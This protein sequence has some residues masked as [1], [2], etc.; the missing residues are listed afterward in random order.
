MLA[1][2]IAHLV[3]RDPAWLLAAAT[4]ESLFFFQP[5]TR[6]ARMKWQEHAEYLCDELAARQQ[7]SGLPLARALAR[8]AEWRVAQAELLAPALAEEPR[9]LLGR[10][11]A[12][13]G[14]GSKAPRASW[15]ARAA[16]TMLPVVILCVSPTFAPGSVRGWGA[17]AFHWADHLAPGQTI[18]V[19]GVLGSIRIEPT[20]GESVVV[21]ATRHGRARSP[22]IHFETLRTLDGFT[23]A[24][25]YPTPA[26]V[27]AN[28]ATPG[29]TGQYNTR[30]NDVEVEFVVHVPPGVNVVA[31]CSAGNITSGVVHGVVRARCR[32]GDI[33]ISTTEYAN[34]E[35]ESGNIRAVMGSA[36]WMGR[37]SL[38]TRA[39]DIRL[40][41]PAAAALEVEARTVTG[42]IRSDFDLGQVRPS[43]WSRLAPRGSLGS[44]TRAT[45]GRGGRSLELSTMAGNIELVRR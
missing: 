22:D 45:L 2:E 15:T 4:L 5:L 26:G 37:M 41:L 25:V 23:I 14:G 16:L 19:Q 9:T 17:P 30:E 6:M 34:A 35:T 18:E 12:L 43:W 32:S 7:G 36:T 27:R 3:R 42:T 24:A 38:R 1:H 21:N 13:L 10:V 29:A 39:G 8:V 31:S 40:A 20:L 33:D 44:H 28:A 11:R